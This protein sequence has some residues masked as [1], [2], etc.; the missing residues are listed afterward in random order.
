MP[1]DDALRHSAKAISDKDWNEIVVL[2][3]GITMDSYPGWHA[4]LSLIHNALNWDTH[5][6]VMFSIVFMFLIFC[7]TPLFFLRY[8][9]SWLAS[10]LCIAIMIPVWILRLMLGRPFI[11]TMAVLMAILFLHRRFSRRKTP[12]VALAIITLLIALSTLIHGSWYLY[13]FLIAAFFIARRWREGFLI[14]IS[15][16][17]GVVIGA[18]FTGRPV[19]FLKQ[20]LMH[21]FL[22]FGNHDLER[23]LVSEFRPDFLNTNII[24]VIA[25]IIIWRFIRK[26][27]NRGLIKDPAFILAILGLALSFLTVRIWIDWG[28]PALLVWLSLEFDSILKKKQNIFYFRRV[29]AVLLLAPILYIAFTSDIRSRWTAWRPM[30]YLSAEDKEQKEWLPGPG[31]IIYSNSM[32]VFYRTFYK[33][34]KAPWRYILGFE[35]ALMP[36]EDLQIYRDIQRYPMTLKYFLPWIEKMRPEDRLILNGSVAHKPNLPE[37][38]WNYTAID[39]WVGRKPKNAEK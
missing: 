28:M 6:L 26:E 23:M 10:L 35:P 18:L 4:L 27:D 22:A 38:E 29:I 34:P 7:L 39:T 25:I 37:L 36:P 9:E 30:D 33:N 14:C 17:L 12:Y 13:V 21:L 16:V 2:R 19:I 11:L 5:S 32:D 1:S 8:P 20:T 31:G 15:W 24:L 3:P